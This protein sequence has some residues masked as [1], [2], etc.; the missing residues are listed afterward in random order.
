MPKR[1]HSAEA[2]VREIRLK[3]RRKFS[4]VDIGSRGVVHIPAST[5]DILQPGRRERVAPEIIEEVLPPPMLRTRW[6]RRTRAPSGTLH[7]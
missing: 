3:I 5:Q 2:Q 4:A 6:G 1:K 7:S